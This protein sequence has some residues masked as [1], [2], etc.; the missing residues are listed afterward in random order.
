MKKIY[1]ICLVL[2]LLVM[3]SVCVYAEAYT[4]T[5]S[6]LK[7]NAYELPFEYHDGAKYDV[8]F[9]VSFEG[10]QT[11]V[12]VYVSELHGSAG[13]GYVALIAVEDGN[14][15]VDYTTRSSDVSDL[16]L[17]FSGAGNEDVVVTLDNV[18]VSEHV[19]EETETTG[20]ETN[21]ETNTSGAESEKE[22]EKETDAVVTPAPDP[23][24]TE[25][26]MLANFFTRL[27]QWFVD[28]KLMIVSVVL[29]GIIIGILYLVKR[30]KSKMD[31]KIVSQLVDIKSD[32]SAASTNTSATDTNVTAA[33]NGL[34]D[35][36]ND[37]NASYKA[38][39]H[40]EDERNKVVSS[41]LETNLAILGILQ[42]VYANN[43]NIP[44]G[45]KDLI[46]YK[47]AKCLTTLENDEELKAIAELVKKS[48]EGASDDEQE[49]G[50]TD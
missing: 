19:I 5:V 40:L 8:S 42:T 48:V 39:Q 6:E 4:G 1:T 47:Y 46:N 10:I 41:V 27:Y 32:A 26:E 3:T 28:N 34:I 24:E 7:E 17:T 43:R 37:M 16:R 38:Q 45:T 33:V 50:K 25:G 29:D 18:I 23:G 14:Y 20:A 12:A 44:Q 13:Q 36:Y 31:D 9:D 30:T 15:H 49:K 35:G 22:T 11:R 21:E 2:A